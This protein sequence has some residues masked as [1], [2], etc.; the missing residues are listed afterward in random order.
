MSASARQ[1]TSKAD[2][3]APCGREVPLC[4]P[5]GTPSGPGMGIQVTCGPHCEPAEAATRNGASQ[6]P[7]MK[8]FTYGE[9]ATLRRKHDAENCKRSSDEHSARSCSLRGS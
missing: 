9:G 5:A 2:A 6:E 7:M 1:A 3:I 4:W 8:A